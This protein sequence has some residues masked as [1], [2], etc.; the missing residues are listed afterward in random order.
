MKAVIA[1]AVA[2]VV[3]VASRPAEGFLLTNSNVTELAGIVVTVTQGKVSKGSLGCTTAGGCVTL[4]V[5]L[6]TNP[7]TLTPLGIDMFGFNASGVDIVAPASWLPDTANQ[8]EDGFGKFTDTVSKSAARDG[9]TSP[10]V[11]TLNKKT[12]TFTPN[13]ATHHATLRP[14]VGAPP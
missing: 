5:Q 10:I 11:F 3:F 12:V 13:D 14:G 4:L 2:A 1:L 9:I 6:T 7:I 8:S